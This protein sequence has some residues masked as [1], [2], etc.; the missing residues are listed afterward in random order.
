MATLRETV[1]QDDRGELRSIAANGLGRVGPAA[2]PAILELARST[3]VRV[4]HG[5]L[6]AA[7]AMDTDQ[8]ADIARSLLND[9]DEG[10]RKYAGIVI[11][12]TSSALA[13]IARSQVKDG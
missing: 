11:E 1:E 8:T 2:A 6:Q 10:I 9:Q 4:R 5:A 3:D 13:G 12:G 7:G